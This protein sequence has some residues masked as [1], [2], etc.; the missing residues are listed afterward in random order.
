MFALYIAITFVLCGCVIAFINN[1]H[2]HI[3]SGGECIS[4]CI[5]VCCGGT[6]EYTDKPHL[7]AVYVCVCLSVCV[8]VTVYIR[9]RMRFTFLWYNCFFQQD[10]PLC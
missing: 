4:N 2:H 10:T 5:D 8:R 1:T 3:K 9:H 6:I 7:H